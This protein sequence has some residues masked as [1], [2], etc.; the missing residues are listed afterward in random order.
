MDT[1]KNSSL[2]APSLYYGCFCRMGGWEI[3]ESL[4]QG[5]EWGEM[6]VTGT[7]VKLLK[8]YPDI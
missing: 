7:D 8:V 6:V 3:V 1:S 5:R 4:G 2:S